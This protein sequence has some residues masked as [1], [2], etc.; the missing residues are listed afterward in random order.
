[1][2]IGNGK[3]DE[4]REAPLTHVSGSYLNV[5]SVD[6][7]GTF[8][9]RDGLPAKRDGFIDQFTII[10]LTCD[11]PYTLTYTQNGTRS[12]PDQLWQQC[13]QG[14]LSMSHAGLDIANKISRT[15]RSLWLCAQA[16]LLLPE[17]RIPH[18]RIYTYTD[19]V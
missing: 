1:M 3:V 10:P 12:I 7:G 13:L 9:K 14:K 5:A 16:I 11:T 15:R 8:G 19:Y 6:Y 2:S 4:A 17:V 18:L